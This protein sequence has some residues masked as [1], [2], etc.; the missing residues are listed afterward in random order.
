[1]VA[2]A[3]APRKG[4]GV[5]LSGALKAVT[6]VSWAGGGHCSS[7]G[8]VVSRAQSPPPPPPVRRGRIQCAVRWASSAARRPAA[9]SEGP[10]AAILATVRPLGPVRSWVGLG[11]VRG[12]QLGRWVRWPVTPTGTG[13]GSPAPPPYRRRLPAGGGLGRPMWWWGRCSEVMMRSA[14]GGRKVLLF[15]TSSLRLGV[16]WVT[17]GGLVRKI[18]RPNPQICPPK[19]FS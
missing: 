9:R 17:P 13:A 10:E 18:A 15:S 6:V 11:V 3:G 14:Q 16:W 1:V 4:Y 7:P 2:R 8:W 19:N 5:C 12:V